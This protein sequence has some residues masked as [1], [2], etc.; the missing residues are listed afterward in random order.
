[1]DSTGDSLGQVL[2]S[3]RFKYPEA[4]SWGQQVL[5][6]HRSGSLHRSL[7]K[8]QESSKGDLDMTSESAGVCKRL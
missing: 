2:I 6:S 8:F 3:D 4:L 7:P 1:M 5:G